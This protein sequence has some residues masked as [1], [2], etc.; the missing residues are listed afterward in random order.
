[1]A[2]GGASLAAA[3]QGGAARATDKTSEGRSE[4]PFIPGAISCRG[5]IAEC[6]HFDRRIA[7]SGILPLAQKELDTPKEDR[8]DGGAAGERLAREIGEEN[9]RVGGRMK[10]RARRLALILSPR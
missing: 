9:A 2:A 5:Y 4:W 10:G 3:S 8:R 7:I 1:M 6:A